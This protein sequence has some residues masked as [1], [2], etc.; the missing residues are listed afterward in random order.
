MFPRAC[1]NEVAFGDVASFNGKE[2]KSPFPFDPGLALIRD[3]QRG[4][5]CSQSLFSQVISVWSSV[6]TLNVITFRSLL[7]YR[8]KLRD[9]GQS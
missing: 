1:P 2:L 3:K 7:N 5:D 8:G 4:L 6:T 9:C